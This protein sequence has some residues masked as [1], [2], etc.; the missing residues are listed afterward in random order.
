MLRTI[1]AIF[2]LSFAFQMSAQT[3]FYISEIT[4]QPN[5]PTT[6]D[7]VAIELTGALSG[8]GA[9]VSA[10]SATVTNNVVNID[11][12]AVDNGGA[13]VI[14]PHTEIIVLGTL[15]AGAY[16][17][18]LNGTNVDDLAAQGEHFFEVTAGGSACDSLNILSIQWHPFTDTSIVVHVSNMNLNTLF[19]Y[20]NFILFDANG[21]TLAIETTDFFGISIDNW[22]ILPLVPGAVIPQTPFLGTLE[23][24][25][26]FTS[27]LACSWTPLFDLCPQA[28]CVT[29]YPNLQNFGG[30]LSIGDF[31]WTILNGTGDMVG[32]STFNM[33]AMEQ[34][35][36]DSI[37]LVPGSY[38]MF[39]TPL[40]QPTG[41]QPYFGVQATGSLAGPDQPVNWDTAPPLAFIVYEQCSSGPN[42]IPEFI[43]NTISVAV[44]GRSITLATNSPKAV[45][46]VKVYDLTGKVVAEAPNAGNWIQ[47]DLND[48]AEGVYVLHMN[49]QVTKVVLTGR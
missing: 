39:C 20:P 15:A 4:V 29:F 24:W 28:P 14:V 23:L 7:N 41:G 22:H 44:N 46:P 18:V 36:M 32:T 9:Y 40:S 25:T 10:A 42:T 33:T 47:I 3:Y 34:N 49:D 6:S 31:M 8:T 5:F 12:T 45:G 27:E 43:S 17:I 30:G 37:C 13:T 16:S 21:D 1:L 19:N 35:A 38:S 48:H 26:D 11:I 2:V